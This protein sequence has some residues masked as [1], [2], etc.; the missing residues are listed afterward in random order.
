MIPPGSRRTTEDDEHH[1]GRADSAALGG[2]LALA[3]WTLLCLLL[4]CCGGGTGEPLAQ[5]VYDATTEAW[6]A[7]AD[8]PA[9]R[10]DGAWC[11]HLDRFEVEVSTSAERHAVACG[12]ATWACLHWRP[13]PGRVRSLFYPVAVLSPWL[14]AERR[15][16]GAAHEMIHA[17]AYCA[18]RTHD[19]GHRDR[20]LWEAGGPD[21]VETTAERALYGTP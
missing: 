14:P 7:R 10:D 21:S 6:D 1:W 17:L 13:L 12:P 19:Y 4:S 15:A 16:A 5:A 20:R 3:G 8:L 18:I 2:F 9:V 11:G